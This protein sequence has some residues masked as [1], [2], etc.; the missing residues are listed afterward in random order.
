MKDKNTRLSR[1]ISL[2]LRHRPEAANISLDEH[3]WAKVKELIAGINSTGRYIDMKMLEDI[4]AQDEKQR[5]SFGDGKR[6]IRANQ[7]HSVPVDIELK[8]VEPPEHLYHGTATKFIGSIRKEGLV[9]KGRLYV[10]LSPD[11]QTAEKVGARHG[12]SVVLKVSAKALYDAG[13][14]F[15]LSANNV[16]LCKNVPSEYIRFPF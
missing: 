16:W 12:K 15:F 6:L 5:Y 9:P 8:A 11:W 3:G 14:P 4:V 2:V 1:F 7:G 13:T 10:H